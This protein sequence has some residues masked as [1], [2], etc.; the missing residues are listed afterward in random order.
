[1]LTTDQW[2]D[3]LIYRLHPR[4]RAFID[5]RS[6]FYDAQVR[7]DYLALMGAKWNWK[8][9]MDRYGFEAALLPLDWPLG[10]LLKSDS[11]WELLYDD[12]HALYFERRVGAAHGEW[13]TGEPESRMAL[14]LALS[15]GPVHPRGNLLGRLK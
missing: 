2:G 9:V 14:E 8:Q 5:G 12:G 1:V 15:E 11:D 4:Y 7:D 10:S 6:D 3:Y 13:S